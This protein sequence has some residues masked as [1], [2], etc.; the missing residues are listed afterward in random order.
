MDK[1]RSPW[2]LFWAES[3]NC[4]TRA[5]R[6]NLVRILSAQHG[7]LDDPSLQSCV[8]AFRTGQ[9]VC[10]PTE[11][12]YALGIDFWN[13]DA[14]ARLYTLKQ[15][16]PEKELPLIAADISMVSSV[17]D[18]GDPRFVALVKKFWPGPLT[19]VL[20][21]LDRSQS[22][23]VR[24][25]SHPIAKQIAEAFG[26]PI[27]STSANRSGDPPISDPKMLPQQMTEKIAIL[28]DAGLTEGGSP[29]TIVSLLERPGRILREGAIPASQLLSLL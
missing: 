26:S 14:L 23:A 11:T 2:E 16:A 19:L 4:W 27:V 1:N 20:P 9:I 8:S 6:C 25:S 12:F 18:T 5:V 24:V 28:V 21:S 7:I 15:R 3:A 10:Y 17:C 29:S 13:E 22:F